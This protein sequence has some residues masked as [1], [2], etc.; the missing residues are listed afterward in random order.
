MNSASK[1]VKKYGEYQ[2]MSAFLT[3]YISAH[4][5]YAAWVSDGGLAGWWLIAGVAS[6]IHMVGVKINGRHGL[7]PAIRLVA[8]IVNSYIFIVLFHQIGDATYSVAASAFAVSNA[9]FVMLN[10]GD[11]S[12]L[13]GEKIS[14]AKR[15]PRCL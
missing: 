10:I 9:W 5:T 13:I 6:I 4:M 8:C 1:N 12:R 11:L 3:A 2:L 15:L 7:T 14:Y